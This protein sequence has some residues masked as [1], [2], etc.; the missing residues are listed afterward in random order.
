MSHG[1]QARRS[2]SR[3]SIEPLRMALLVVLIM[4]SAAIKV[5]FLMLLKVN[6]VEDLE[7]TSALNL[8]LLKANGT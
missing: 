1:F 3:K 5:P 8:T 6:T 7:D 2:S 4:P